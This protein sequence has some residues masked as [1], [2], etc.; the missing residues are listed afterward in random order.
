MPKAEIRFTVSCT[1]PDEHDG[2]KHHDDCDLKQFL[3]KAMN[4]ETDRG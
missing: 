4:R 1:C 3:D 2:D